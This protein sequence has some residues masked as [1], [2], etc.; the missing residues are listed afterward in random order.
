[1][2]TKSEK[3]IG[4]N[5]SRILSER[6][7]KR[8]EFS[9]MAEIHETHLSRICNGKSIPQIGKIIKMAKVLN[10]TVDDLVS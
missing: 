1:V 9:V 3:N 8:C 2:K 6:R 4:K 5:L 10:L 7:I